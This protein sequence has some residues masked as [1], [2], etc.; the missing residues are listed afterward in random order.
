MNMVDRDRS[1]DV[2]LDLDATVLVVDA[3]GHRVKFDVKLV[4]PSPERP[5][6]LS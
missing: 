2:L 1:L 3:N 4:E 5:H 6:G